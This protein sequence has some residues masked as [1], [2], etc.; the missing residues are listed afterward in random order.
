[1]SFQ[2]P[3]GTRPRLV[4]HI[5][6][7]K[8]GTS[9]LQSALEAQREALLA[10]G[11]L[12]PRTDR[13]PLPELPK[14]CSVYRAAASGDAGFQAQERE[15][16]LAEFA[17]SGAHTLILSEEGL[18]E[19]DEALPRF[20]EPLAEHFDIDVLCLL[21][22]QDRFV[23]SLFNQFVREQARQEARPLL[24][25]VRAPGTR[26]RLDY[27]A[28]LQRWAALPARLIVRDFDHPELRRQGMVPAMAGLIGLPPLPLP[29]ARLNPSPDMRLALLL[30]RLNRQRLPYELGPL[31]QAARALARQGTP[32]VRHLLGSQERQR[33][34][35]EVAASNQRLAEAFGV[36]FDA[37]LPAGETPWATEEADPGYL[38][39]LLAQ[40][41]RQGD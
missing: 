36:Q 29:D 6:T 30:N 34:L 35:A 11:W 17:A 1:M 8:T 12:Y 15:A 16:L 2:P 32:P 21:R 25:F 18:S 4:L 31:L 20:F 23:E 38:A 3:P 39:Q 19:P 37:E 13:A 5:G 10:Q 27:H 26:A 41:S 22:R 28:L 14:H 9:A 24:A 33:L 7:H 40:L